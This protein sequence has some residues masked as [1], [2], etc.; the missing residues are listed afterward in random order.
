[1]SFSQQGQDWSVAGWNKSRSGGRIGNE[2]KEAALNRARRAGNVVTE[3]KHNGVANKSAHQAT[4][5]MR[6]LEEDTDNFK[7]ETVDRSLSQALQKARMDKGMTQKALATAINEKPQVIG[8]YESGRAIP[9]G[10]IIVKI[11]RALGCRLPRAPKKKKP[12]S[13]D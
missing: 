12:A 11:E 8:E 5:N 10:Q 9:N 13:S 3:A 1:M 6:K 4:G 2:S 7:H